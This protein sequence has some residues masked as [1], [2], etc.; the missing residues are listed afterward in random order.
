MSEEITK[1]ASENQ[2]QPASQEAPAAP[3]P[4]KQPEPPK[5]PEKTPQQISAEKAA[6]RAEELKTYV[7]KT[8]RRRDGKTGLVKVMAYG[9]VKLRTINKETIEQAHTFTVETEGARW[10]PP[11]TKFLAEHEEVKIDQKPSASEIV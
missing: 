10:N 1:P 4:P 8:F 7:G 3:E 9:G 6:A 11:A 2:Q 5:V